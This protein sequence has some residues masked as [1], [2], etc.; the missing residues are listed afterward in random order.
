M[1]LFSGLK[2]VALDVASDTFYHKSVCWWWVIRNTG[3]G[4]DRHAGKVKYKI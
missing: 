3:G 4:E 1:P 2:Q